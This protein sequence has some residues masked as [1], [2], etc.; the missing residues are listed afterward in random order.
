MS[1]SISMQTWDNA[2]CDGT[3]AS[4]VPDLLGH[5]LSSTCPEAVIEVRGLACDDGGGQVAALNGNYEI[6]GRYP[7]DHGRPYYRGIDEANQGAVL[8]YCA[9][10][11]AW[12]LGFVDVRDVELAGCGE[13]WLVGGSPVDAGLDQLPSATVRRS[14]RTAGCAV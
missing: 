2:E 10:N 5:I 8:F 13:L 12:S 11:G 14:T 9:E 1:R 4:E 6:E 7:E 3:A